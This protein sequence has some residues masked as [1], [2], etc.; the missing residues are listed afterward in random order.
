MSSDRP[1]RPA[2]ATDQIIKELRSQAGVQFD[3]QRIAELTTV[4]L[5]QAELETKGAAF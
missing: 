2:L 4:A 3:P 5:I 1:Y